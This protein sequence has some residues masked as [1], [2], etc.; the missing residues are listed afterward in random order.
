M[1]ET[2]APTTHIF[3]VYPTSSPTRLCCPVTR[4]PVR[5]VMPP[6]GQPTLWNSV[7]QPCTPFYPVYTHWSKT[8]DG[9]GFPHATSPGRQ[10]SFSCVVSHFSVSV[11]S[12][13]P[14]CVSQ[15]ATG[16]QNSSARILPIQ[17]C[18]AFCLKDK[19]FPSRFPQVMVFSVIFDQS[20]FWMHH[21]QNQTG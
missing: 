14:N 7:H 10:T 12:A 20:Q 18:L 5:Q 19:R 9:S 17:S 6:I 15:P 16:R 8:Q 2:P 1:L 21:S 4:Q 11:F 3:L 13:A